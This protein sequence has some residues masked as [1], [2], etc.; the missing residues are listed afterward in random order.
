MTM[1]IAMSIFV[2]GF[3]VGFMS[4]FGVRTGYKLI[5]EVIEEEKKETLAPATNWTKAKA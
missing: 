1:F 3:L 2:I 4:Y 5:I